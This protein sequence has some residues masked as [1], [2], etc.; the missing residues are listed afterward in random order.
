M[1]CSEPINGAELL[2]PETVT[3]F[4]HSVKKSQS[5]TLF[6]RFKFSLLLAQLCVVILLRKQ[7][8]L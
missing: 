5:T 4:A 7:I 6:S 8:S 1:D 3:I 2:L